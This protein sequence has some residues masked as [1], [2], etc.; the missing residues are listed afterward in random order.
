[1]KSVWAVLTSFYA[2]SIGKKIIVAVTGLGLLLFLAGHLVGNLLIYAGAH[3]INDYAYWL[4]NFGHG[5]GI[6]IAR[7]G[8]LGMVVAHI[9]TT[10]AL[11]RQNRA[12]RPSRYAY[13]GTVQASKASRTM[14][15]TGTIILVFI[16]YHVMHFTL[17][18]G[19]DYY[20][21]QT[22]HLE[23]GH[24]NVYKMVID[25]FSVWYVSAFYIFAMAL[26]CSH[27]SHGFSSVFQ[28]LGLRTEKTW[29]I[30]RASGFAYAAV[31]FFGNISIPI[32]IMVGIVK[33]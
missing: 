7:A 14:M 24:H 30:I 32:S 20:S 5:A 17:G 18:V 11:V 3:A 10:I 12:A 13:E 31:I 26:L 23:G 16:V 1:M 4:K 8:L 22:Y 27:L 6:W 19:N 28:T 33:Y 29:P 9:V 25:G 15:W 21:N 2:S